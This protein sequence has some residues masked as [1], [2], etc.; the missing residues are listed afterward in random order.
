MTR[1]DAV[2]IFTALG[3]HDASWA[4]PV[5]GGHVRPAPHPIGSGTYRGNRSGGVGFTRV[6]IRTCRTHRVS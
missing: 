6:A 5:I 1:C 2:A 4:S 3:V